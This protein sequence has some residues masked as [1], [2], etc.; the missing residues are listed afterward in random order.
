VE[1]HVKLGVKNL[2]YNVITLKITQIPKTVNLMLITIEKTHLLTD[3][4]RLGEIKSVL[5]V[6]KQASQNMNMILT[7]SLVKTDNVTC[8][9]RLLNLSKMLLNT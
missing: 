6:L 2:D 8:L 4:N 3:V 9:S 1:H 7:I 5:V